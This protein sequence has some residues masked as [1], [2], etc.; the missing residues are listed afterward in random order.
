MQVD[1]PRNPPR[2]TADQPAYCQVVRLITFQGDDL[3]FSQTASR[4]GG[5]GPYPT[6]S[7]SAA[8]STLE[9]TETETAAIESATQ[10]APK[11]GNCRLNLT[12]PTVI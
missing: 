8:Q 4:V 5:A 7:T 12:L 11:G 9:L 3:T 2:P 1:T 10:T 6:S